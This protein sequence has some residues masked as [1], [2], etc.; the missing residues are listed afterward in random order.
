MKIFKYLTV[1]LPLSLSMNLFAATRY[2]SDDVSIYEHSGPS[3][4]YRII[5]TLNVGTPVETLQYDEKTKFMQI[6]KAN[7]KTSWVQNRELQETQPAKVL[8]PKV[9]LELQQAQQKLANIAQENEQEMQNTVQS[10][11]EKEELIANLMD[12]KQ[13]L[14]QTI[15]ELKA[16]N[17]ELDLLQDTKDERIKMEWMMYGGSVLFFGLLIGL[18]I[19][20]LPRRKKR[21][22]NW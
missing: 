20:F 19:P 3:L 13:T 2:V 8:L 14:L 11:N 18:I 6:K 12:E 21:N 10:L 5:G 1:I 4:Q 9:Q 15:D 16:R 17:L 22:N 7:G